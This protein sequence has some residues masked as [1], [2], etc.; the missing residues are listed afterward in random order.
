MTRHRVPFLVLPGAR[1]RQFRKMDARRVV[2][3]L[4]MRQKNR[5]GSARR[6]TELHLT[7]SHLRRHLNTIVSI[8]QHCSLFLPDCAHVPTRILQQHCSYG[9]PKSRPKSGWTPSMLPGPSARAK[10]SYISPPRRGESTT[11]RR[12]R[13]SR[14]KTTQLEVTMH[15]LFRSA[16][17]KAVSTPA[18][19]MQPTN[20]HRSL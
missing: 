14:R 8:L 1:C 2:V 3:V 19:A 17:P 9:R 16:M 7:S 4:G 13:P 12:P 18:K 11:T 6:P 10:G 15:D 5:R 20:P